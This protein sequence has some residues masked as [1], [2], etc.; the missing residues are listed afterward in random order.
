MFILFLIIVY[1]FYMA[2]QNYFYP[3]YN[4]MCYVNHQYEYVDTKN[5]TEYEIFIEWCVARFPPQKNV[6]TYIIEM[7]RITLYNTS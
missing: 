2:Y 3:T 1:S 6:D 4:A 5:K 7:I